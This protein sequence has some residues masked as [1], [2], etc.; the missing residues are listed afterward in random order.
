MLLFVLP[1]C[2]PR[3]VGPSDLAH[4]LFIMRRLV[5]EITPLLLCWI[6][7]RTSTRPNDTQ[8]LPECKWGAARYAP[9]L[10]DHSDS[11]AHPGDRRLQPAPLFGR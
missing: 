7:S 3:K 4:L 6:W 5:Q 2:Y 1:D 10:P 9:Q 11:V 8:F